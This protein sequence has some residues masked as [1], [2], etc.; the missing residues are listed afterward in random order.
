MKQKY[1]IYC[2]KFFDGVNQELRDRVTIITCG[3]KIIEVGEN[4]QCP[5]DAVYIDLSH[6]TVTPGLID[7]HVHFDFVG[8]ETFNTYCI[9]DSDEMKALNTL[10]NAIKSLDLG[11]T[12]VRTT[13]TAF[14]G[15]GAV[16]VKRAIDK[17]FFSASR[18]VVAPHALGISGGHWDFSMF[19]MNSNPDVCEHIEQPYAFGAG[20]DAFKNL[21]RKQ[22]KYGADFIKI[23]AAGGFAS[24]NDDPGEMQLD[25][26]EMKAIIDTTKMYSKISTAHAYTSE[27]IDLLISYGVSGIEHGTLMKPHTANLIEEN[28]ILYV[29]TIKSLMPPDE[30]VDISKLPPKSPAYERKL[31]KYDVQLK[32]SRKTVVDLII[33]S[34]A[35][36]GIGSDIVALYNN[37]DT[38]R[39]IKAWR[40]LGIPALRTLVAATSGSAKVIGSNDLGVI[41]PGKIADIVAWDKDLLNDHTAFSNC[42][43]VMKEG[44]VIKSQGQ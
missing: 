16:D 40:D 24:P 37:Y 11:V 12:T 30:D 43:F 28:N 26:T 23:M 31:K 17:G 4:I 10:R 19:Y 33:N 41:S 9:T 25:P 13:G 2:G 6:L 15:F 20:A 29:P 22:M 7:S 39:E 44:H 5:S 36:V 3:N 38:W 34:K 32:E 1:C 21:V 27:V 18:M 42:N 35:T 8:S 14:R